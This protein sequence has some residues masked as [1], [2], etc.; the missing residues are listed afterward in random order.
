VLKRTCFARA[1]LHVILH[2]ST[3]LLFPLSALIFIELI[4]DSLVSLVVMTVLPGLFRFQLEK[5]FGRT[6]F[7]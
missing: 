2:N 1:T 6:V 3:L 4:K 5:A 7:V